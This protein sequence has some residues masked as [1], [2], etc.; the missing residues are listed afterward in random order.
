LGAIFGLVKGVLYCVLITF[1][2]V[3]LSEAARQIVLQSRSGD[4]IARGIRNANPIIPEDLRTY[5]GKY[6]D[7]LDEK[8]HAP[9]AAVTPDKGVPGTAA[10]TATDTSGAGTSSTGTSTASAPAPATTPAAKQETKKRLR[11]YLP[12]LK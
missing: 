8:L 4:L 9:P 12:K 5:L 7:E 1:F 10:A 11:D 6:I 3:T 2:A